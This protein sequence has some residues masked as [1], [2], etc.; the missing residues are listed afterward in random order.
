MRDNVA[1][2]SVLLVPTPC[3]GVILLTL[4]LP[5]S[6]DDLYGIS[7]HFD[8]S[9][10]PESKHRAP[11][12][13]QL[14]WVP[15]W[16]GETADCYQELRNSYCHKIARSLHDTAFYLGFGDGSR[17]LKA[18]YHNGKVQVDSEVELNED[19]WSAEPTGRDKRG[20]RNGGNAR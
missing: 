19:W 1:P 11:S 10:N 4:F 5:Q 14:V 17:A 6:C 9:F 13:R 12:L 3:A 2:V 20:S 16:H 7:D 8:F 18:L 15:V